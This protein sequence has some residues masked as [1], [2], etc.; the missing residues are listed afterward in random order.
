MAT[1]TDYFAQAQLSMTAYA[2]GL[3]PGMFGAANYPAY[4]AALVDAGMST[5]QATEFA[6][7]YTVIDQSPENDPTGFSATIFADQDGNKYFAIR[8][9]NGDPLNLNMGIP[10]TPYLISSRRAAPG[11]KQ[12]LDL[13]GRRRRN[14]T[15]GES[16]EPGQWQPLPTEM[17]DQPQLVLAAA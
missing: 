15:C 13:C 14:C 5:S 1:I 2:V 9:S 4:V 11:R 12:I 6:N 10:G 7:T 16:P 3:Q 17:P 8:G